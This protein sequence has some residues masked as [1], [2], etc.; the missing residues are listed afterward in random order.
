MPRDDR[1]ELSRRFRTLAE[2]NGL[3]GEIKWQKVSTKKIA[4]YKT[5]IDFFF[6][7]VAMKFRVILVDGERL[8]YGKYHDNDRELG[9]Y[10][11]YYEMLVKWLL[12]QHEYLILLD[13][14]QNA[15]RDRYITLRYHL[16]RNTKGISWISDLTIISSQQT[17]LAQ[18]TDL[19]VGA[20]AAEWGS[21]KPESAKAELVRYIVERRKTP[22]YQ[23]AS[24]SPRFEKFNVFRIRLNEN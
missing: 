15:S 17:P 10:K 22:A 19:L 18:L 14:K 23:T 21:T 13:H 7:Q 8:N 6:D 4:G 20:C 5:L 16:E 3:N 1:D 24:A 11:F 12:P 2:A 9:F